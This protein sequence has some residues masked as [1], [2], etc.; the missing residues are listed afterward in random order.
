[1]DIYVSRFRFTF[2][3]VDTFF[4]LEIFRERP[5]ATTSHNLST[6]FIA[7]SQLSYF[8]MKETFRRLGML[9]PPPHWSLNCHPINDALQSA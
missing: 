1:M 2:T 8:D 9:L 3:H 4:V 5:W 6:S 7:N